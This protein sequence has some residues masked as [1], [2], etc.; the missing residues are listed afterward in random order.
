MRAS[1]SSRSI[2]PSRFRSTAAKFPS[3]H[4]V[5]SSAPSTAHWRCIQTFRDGAGGN[6]EAGSW[7]NR[8]CDGR[9]SSYEVA[10]VT[11]HWL[12]LSGGRVEGLLR[13]CT[14]HREETVGEACLLGTLWPPEESA[15]DK[16]PRWSLGWV[17]GGVSRGMGMGERAAG[18]DRIPP[19]R[20][21]GEST[22]KAGM[23][24]RA[25]G[26]G[27]TAASPWADS[28][29]RAGRGRGFDTASAPPSE[30][31]LGD[32]APG[33]ASETPTGRARGAAASRG[34]G[35][36]GSGGVWIKAPSSRVL[37]Y[38]SRGG[39]APTSA[40]RSSFLLVDGSVGSSPTAHGSD[41]SMAPLSEYACSC[42]SLDS[43][44]WAAA[45]GWADRSAGGAGDVSAGALGGM[46]RRMRW[47]CASNSSK[48]T[49]RSSF[50]SISWKKSSNAVCSAEPCR[51]RPGR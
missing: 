27:T 44:G 14:T 33:A 7:R 17:V 9:H 37:A 2:T 1:N 32:T 42:A 10:S 39:R 5:A 19:V 28:G 30:R 24:E 18:E 26:E 25:R 47:M 4:D 23:A 22:G 20:P 43:P 29:C 45:R 12:L 36:A 6:R 3:V 48:V 49:A 40:P 15:R 50:V 41:R 16:S 11:T 21:E 51:I 38:A 8:G 35:C 46:A 34:G 31:A 13:R